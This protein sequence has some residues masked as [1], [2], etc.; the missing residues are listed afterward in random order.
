MLP[1]I[2]GTVN[3][4]V[5]I[6]RSLPEHGSEQLKMAKPRK[7]LVSDEQILEHLWEEEDLGEVNLGNDSELDSDPGG[8]EQQEDQVY[9]VNVLVQV[10]WLDS[11]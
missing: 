4:H 7:V 5:R 3:S 10:Q 6:L 8:E 1:D 9:E 11:Y 2:F